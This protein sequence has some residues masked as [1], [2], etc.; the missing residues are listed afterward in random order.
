MT[1]VFLPGVGKVSQM[2]DPQQGTGSGHDRCTEA[3]A[4]MIDVTYKIGP[5]AQAAN[6]DG[7]KIMYD[8]VAWL[9]NGAT[10]SKLEDPAWIADWVK[11]HSDN[12]ITLTKSGSATFA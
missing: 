11:Q 1:R 9:N 5:S 3:V 8:F 12:A 10:T 2:D 4:A 7:Q 6:P